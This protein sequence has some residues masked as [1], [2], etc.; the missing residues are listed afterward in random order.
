MNRFKNG[1]S[2]A[3][4]LLG[5]MSSCFACVCSNSHTEE[6]SEYGVF[7]NI[8]N[9][10]ID[11]L[12]S[13]KTI[14]IDAE[15]F[16]KDDISELHEDG[17]C[18]YTYLNVGSVEEFRDYFE[19]FQDITLGEYDNW[20]DEQWVDV[21]D[22]RWKKHIYGLAQEYI[23]KGIDGFFIDNCDVY[24]QYKTEQIYISLTEILQN[25]MEMNKKII[26]NGGDEFVKEY[27]QQNGEISSIMTGVNQE[28]V[29]TC[30]DADATE[31]YE[32]YLA[33]CKGA[34][35]EV[36]TIEYTT[37]AKEIEQIRSF[38]EKNRYKY[39]ISDSIDLD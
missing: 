37:D 10:D 12:E 15:L 39:Y 19:E 13:Y 4:I 6:K 30:H 17:T 31:Y 28:E 27:Y 9:S 18:V 36:F 11:R 29:I 2:L 3:L 25:L 5:I 34:G 35:I 22:L 8:D 16:S 24:F 20:K 33:L 21:S 7:L 38:C 1:I 14:V 32:E 26:I 23:E